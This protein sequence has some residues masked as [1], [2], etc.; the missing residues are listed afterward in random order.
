MNSFLF[1]PEYHDSK[2]NYLNYYDEVEICS[3]SADVQPK[4]A[5]QV[6]NRS[7]VNRSDLVICCI[8][9]NSGEALQY[10]QKQDKMTV[11]LAKRN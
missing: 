7:I 10:A 5:I 8:Q 3:E 1:Q 6:R 4:S 9:H 2:Q 11:I